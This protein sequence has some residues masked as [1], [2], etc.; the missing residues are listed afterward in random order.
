MNRHGVMRGLRLVILLVV[1]GCSSVGGASSTRP[2]ASSVSASSELLV[3]GAPISSSPPT[4][5]SRPE[6]DQPRWRPRQGAIWQWQLSG[7]LDP[8]IAAQVY[9]VDLFDTSAAD[10]RVLHSRGIRVVCY[11]SAGSWEPGRPDSAAFAAGLRGRP[12]EGFADER[13]LDIR[14]LDRLLPIMARRLDLCRAEG[15]DGAEPDNVDGFANRSGF[16]LTSAQQ[17]TYNRALATLAHARGLAVA[18]KNDLDQV[19]ELQPSFDFAVNEQCVEFDECGRLLPFIRAGKAVLHVEY[20]LPR[21]RFCPV[22]Q[23]LRFS[24]LLKNV[25]LGPFRHSC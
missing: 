11:F 1:V 5:H 7:R 3:A 6:A 14:R 10:V 20:H 9:D 8:T 23:S 21:T 12:M 4:N 18:L 17:L 22:T 24:S 16:P 19:A 13:W 15:F 25:D 2:T